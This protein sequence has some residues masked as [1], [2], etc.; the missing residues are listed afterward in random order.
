MP[1]ANHPAYQEEL[2]RCRYTL[3]YV[4]KTLEATYGKKEKID[5]EVERLKK[6]INSDSSQNYIDLMI[7]SLLQ[8]SMTLKLR[9][10]VTATSK[11]YFAR[12]DFRE[13]DGKETEKLYIGK[14]SLMREEDQQ[15]IIVDWRAPVANLYYE[16]RLGEAHYACPDG[17]I[18]GSMLLKRQYSIEEGE[19]REIFDIDITTNDEFLQAYLGAN[20]DNRLKQIVSTIQVEQNKIIR[21]DMWKSLIVQGAAGSGKTTIALHRIAYLIYTHD[22]TLDPENFMII[23]PNRLFLNYISEVLPELGVERVVQSTFETFA[24]DLLGKKFKIKDQNEKLLSFITRTGDGKDGE[25]SLHY[26]ASV[27]KSSMKF[28]DVIDK[29]VE[30]IEKDFI[31]KEDFKLEGI[32]IFSYQEINGLFLKEYKRL[33]LVKRIDEIKKHLNTRIKAKREE[34]I[35]RLHEKSDLKVLYLKESMKDSEGRQKLIIKAIDDRNNAIQKIESSSKKVVNEYIKSISRISP[36]EYYSSLIMDSSLLKDISSGMEDQTVIEHMAEYTGRYL[37]TG[38]I[39]LEDFAPL[40]YL[41]YLIHGIDEKIP[42]KQIIIDE[43]QDFSIFQLYA[44]RQIIKY[45]SF[46]I[47]GDLNQGIHSY[48]GVRNWGDV[49]EQ[50]F[51]EK[52]GYLTLEQ[53]YRTTVEIMDSANKVIGMLGENESFIAKPVIRHGEKVH[54]QNSLNF[55]DSVKSIKEKIMEISANGL[56]SV[57]VIGRTPE[58]CKGIFD[59]MKEDLPE[60]HIITGKEEEYKG[61]L[62]IVPSYLSKGLEFDVV[63]ITGVENYGMSEL[64]IKLLYVAMTRALHVLYLYFSDQPTPLIEKIMI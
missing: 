13:I 62:V 14:M 11:P 41:K 23:A 59:L 34:I 26:R 30:H 27:F 5:K 63:F 58:E 56:K 17:E 53:S 12:V 39:E 2:E 6:H 19:L 4:E 16:E 45:S 24:M 32:K 36:W 15:V 1:A 28:K 7:N 60:L 31:P 18:K 3:D 46:T 40:I 48:R 10:L 33:P 22:K 57:A 51:G 35:Y 61:G 55:I 64:D 8:G 54:I 52:A 43:A 47:L 9:N 25:N 21:A 29:Y 20:A 42:V 49:L 50:V 37:K 38:Y 44:L